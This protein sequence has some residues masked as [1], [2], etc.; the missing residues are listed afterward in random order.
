MRILYVSK[1]DSETSSDG[2]YASSLTKA[3]ERA[4]NV[5]VV[6]GTIRAGPGPHLDQPEASSLGANIAALASEQ[7][8]DLVHLHYEPGLYSLPGL[9]S[10][11]SHARHLPPIVATLHRVAAYDGRWRASGIRQGRAVYQEWLLARHV[12]LFFVH[13]SHSRQLIAR[14][15][16]RVRSFAHPMPI[17]EDA[18]DRTPNMQGPLLFLGN[19]HPGKGILELVKALRTLPHIE[20][21]VAGK[22]NPKWAHYDRM[23]DNEVALA[24]NVRLELGWVTTKRKHELFRNASVVAL[25]YRSEGSGSLILQESIAHGRPVAAS[26]IQPLCSLVEEAR[27]GTCADPQDTPAFAE[28]IRS[29]VEAP[30]GIYSRSLDRARSAGSPE[31]V[32]QM[33][34]SQYEGLLR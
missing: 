6:R 17:P 21:V 15:Y 22:R 3:L 18:C 10:I 23:V 11:A 30:E 5:E 24:T 14:R 19:H 2:A 26:D 16:P 4:G 29:V 28:A 34:I 9:Q 25:P 31:T 1:F 20:A 8:A 7:A 32:A 33:L 13:A 12:R 27:V